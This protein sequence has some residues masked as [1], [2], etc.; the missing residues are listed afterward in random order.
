M[1]QL[2]VEKMKTAVAPVNERPIV[3]IEPQFSGLDGYLVLLSPVPPDGA[4]WGLNVVGHMDMNSVGLAMTEE[5]I[6][7]AYENKFGVHGWCQDPEIGN[8]Y[9][10]GSDG[11]MNFYRGLALMTPTGKYMFR[12]LPIANAETYWL[13]GFY[14]FTH[15]H[16]K[17]GQIEFQ[18]D[19]PLLGQMPAQWTGITTD[20]TY[21]I[22]QPGK[23]FYPVGG[24][25]MAYLLPD[26]V[27]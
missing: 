5:Q 2:K 17:L 10:L 16:I 26:Q 12:K 21:F 8:A 11:F 27:G 20:L 25:Y 6:I 14:E 15:P 7:A 4:P 24:G 9:D 22:E 19:A 13:K 1:Y 3:I 18:A 23:Y